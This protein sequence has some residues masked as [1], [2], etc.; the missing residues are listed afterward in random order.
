MH[1]DIIII[2]FF[3]PRVAFGKR[4]PTTYSTDN[5]VIDF[6]AIIYINSTHGASNF[7]YLP[8]FIPSRCFSHDH[9]TV[10]SQCTFFS[11]KMF[12]WHVVRIKTKNLW[13]NILVRTLLKV[14]I[15][16]DARKTING[17]KLC[18]TAQSYSLSTLIPKK[19]TMLLTNEYKYFGNQ[20]Q[21]FIG[22]MEY[23]CSDSHINLV[24]IR[25]MLEFTMSH[26]QTSFQS[27]VGH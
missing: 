6:A 16:P 8:N 4:Q 13:P 27:Q 14:R 19:L 18:Y 7:L 24:I 11:T 26:F 12:L 10:A 2:S 9:H 21:T 5:A 23:R 3:C 1:S 20:V 17:G 15:R 25:S 22:N